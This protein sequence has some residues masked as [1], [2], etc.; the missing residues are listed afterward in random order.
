MEPLAPSGARSPSVI[1]DVAAT[2]DG[3]RISLMQWSVF[4][5]TFAAS[6]LDGFDTMVM[7]FLAPAISG[8]WHASHGAFGLVFSATLLGAA[9]G[10]TFLGALADRF[11]RRAL[12]LVSVGWFAFLTIGC[13]M[14]PDLKI[15]VA[16]RFLAGLGLGGA[17]PNMLALAAEYAPARRRSTIVSVITWGTPL[18]AVL[19]GLVS[20]LVAAAYGW[21]V[22]L[23]GA[24][25]APLLLF[26]L[27][28]MLLPE[29]V[30]FLA[31]RHEA[32]DRLRAIMQRVAQPGDVPSN[33]RFNISERS[34]EKAGIAA[35]FRDGLAPGTILLSAAMFSS[36]LL[37]FLL[38]NWT[39]TML[40]QAGIPLSD[41][42]LGTMVL[43]FSGIIGSLFVARLVDGHRRGSLVLGLSYLGAVAATL[44]T[45][46]ATG[47]TGAPLPLLFA[48]LAS[49]GF[50]LI[51]TQISLSAYITAFFPTAL[52]ATGIGFNN[53]V[54]R[55]GSLLGPALGGFLL[56]AGISPAHILA[57]GA[58]PGLMSAAALFVLA[59]FQS[60]AGLPSP[61]HMSV[62]H[63]GLA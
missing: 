16:L 62:K 13:A 63:R 28:W 29:S 21:R 47:V 26:P 9:I 22:V 5:L 20:S 49:C 4:A 6:L 57:A 60:R 12:I 32:Q 52:R 37:S 7:S 11:G 15:L 27:L 61:T 39:P 19:G 17:I 36:L 8:Q 43:N 46:I 1:L 40:K 48:C 42:I 56:S 33:A 38:V 58:L 24:G 55:A 31:V 51:G 2:I 30:R 45:G 3:A 23:L 10:A 14:A 44:G 18:G 53:A 25:I 34:V 50:F 59:R 35:L 54:A 41:A